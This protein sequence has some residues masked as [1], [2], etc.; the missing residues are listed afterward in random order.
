MRQK[1]G[2]RETKIVTK[3]AELNLNDVGF[4]LNKV[5]SR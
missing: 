5:E 2:R 4:I 1:A 3:A